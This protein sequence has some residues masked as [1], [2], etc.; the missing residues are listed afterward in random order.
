[1]ISLEYFTHPKHITGLESL[2]KPRLKS[3]L[4]NRLSYFYIWDLVLSAGIFPHSIPILLSSYYLFHVVFIFGMTLC[5]EMFFL[6]GEITINSIFLI[7]ICLMQTNTFLFLGSLFA[8]NTCTIPVPTNSEIS[9]LKFFLFLLFSILNL[10][11]RKAILYPKNIVRYNINLYPFY[12][13][14]YHFY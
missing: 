12:S 6:V 2:R 14:A 10:L 1:M 4:F 11:L 8:I 13:L 5:S 7:F 3:I 9:V